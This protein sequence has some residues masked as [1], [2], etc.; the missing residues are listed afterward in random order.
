M[1]RVLAAEK[2]VVLREILEMAITGLRQKT[3]KPTHA[4]SFTSQA[5]L[6]PP[7]LHVQSPS[8]CP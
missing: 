2:D 4:L 3:W 8:L 1:N 7:G 6:N 5:P